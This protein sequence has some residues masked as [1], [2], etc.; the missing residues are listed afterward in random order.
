MAKNRDNFRIYSDLECDVFLAPLGTTLPTTLDAPIAPFEEVGFLSEDG[1]PINREVDVTKFKAYQG[2]STL[3]V[4]ITSDE[5]T[6]TF[7]AAEEK[8]L[9]SEL[10]WGHGAATVAGGVATIDVPEAAPVAQ[11]AAV[12]QFV[13]GGVTKLYAC[14]NVQITPNGEVPHATEDGTMYPFQ[15][16]IVGGFTIITDA[17]VFVETDEEE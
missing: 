16:E 8:P 1:V 10:Y 15:G 9:V 2:A 12:L 11:R 5:R 3:R 14:E 6:F 7:T 4:K 13:D 17:P